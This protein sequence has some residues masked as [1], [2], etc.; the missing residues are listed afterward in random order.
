MATTNAAADLRPKRFDI[1]AYQGD[2]WSL[3]I[4][5]T[6]VNLTGAVIAAK[7]R[8]DGATVSTTLTVSS[9]APGLLLGKFFIGQDPAAAGK[10]DVR[11]TQTG[12]LPRTY[13]KGA[14]SVEVDYA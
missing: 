3:E 4:S 9:T 12:A 1:N 8:A 10:Y 14:I 2:A 7:F 11:I 13:V 6:G 5:L